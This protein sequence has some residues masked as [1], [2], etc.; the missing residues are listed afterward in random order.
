MPLRPRP[1]SRTKFLTLYMSWRPKCVE[2]SGKV[3]PLTPRT[4]EPLEPVTTRSL[5][6]LQ[7]YSEALDQMIRHGGEAINGVEL[8]RE[9]PEGGS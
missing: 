7:L 2:I 5:R 3:L 4:G 8:L 6:A 9:A 1:A